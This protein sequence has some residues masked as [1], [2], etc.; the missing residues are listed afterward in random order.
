MEHL[1]LERVVLIGHDRGARVARR[2]ALDYPVQAAS[3]IIPHLIKPAK[4]TG[5]VSVEGEPVNLQ[6]PKR[7]FARVGVVSQK[8][9]EQMWDLTVEDQISFPL[10]NRENRS[11]ERPEILRRLRTL[12]DALKLNHLLGRQTKD[13]SGGERRAVA[14][15]GALA[16]EPDL[17]VL[18]EPSSGLDPGA[19]ERLRE[20]LLALV[21]R[22]QTLLIAEQDLSWLRD[23][24]DRI[25]LISPAGKVTEILNGPDL[26]HNPEPFNRVGLTPP[27]RSL[28]PA[29]TDTSRD[30][31]DAET[32]PALAETES[33]PLAADNRERERPLVLEVDGLYCPRPGSSIWRF[34]RKSRVS[35]HVLEELDFRV[36]EGEVVALL[37]PNGAGKTTLFRALMGLHERSSG[38]VRLGGDPDNAMSVA[39]RAGYLGY[40][41]QNPAHMLFAATLMEEL[42]FSL[43]VHGGQ[44]AER[45]EVADLA[46]R[47]G[48][49]RKLDTPPFALSFR[50]L[51]H[52]ALA[53][54]EAAGPKVLIFDEPLIGYDE[55][56]RRRLI[57]FLRDLSSAGRGAVIATHDLW[58]AGQVADRVDI[59]RSGRVDFSG[60]ADAAWRSPVFLSLGWLDPS[61]EKAALGAGRDAGREPSP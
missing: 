53:C 55:R 13:L 21:S 35:P 27:S 22:K 16:A 19:R 45:T 44:V 39:Q 33:R 2:Y 12:V 54:V 61:S 60:P 23:L 58:F 11:V 4:E 15:A 46:K 38:T 56:W 10:E 37:G 26:H 32:T 3:G 17:L 1:D 8:V 25:V 42:E 31:S 57:R 34:G 40:V 5:T 18:D 47:Y 30:E 41:S 29:Y 28:A 36:S 24:A 49:E 7:L 6:D 52:L 50:Q 59:L 51:Q 43:S 9:D 20:T 48:L 14:L